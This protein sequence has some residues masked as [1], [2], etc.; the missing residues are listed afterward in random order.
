[1]DE[2]TLNNLRAEIQFTPRQ[3]LRDLAHLLPSTTERERWS[4][5]KARLEA[6]TGGVAPSLFMRQYKRAMGDIELAEAFQA[7]RPEGCFC[8]GAGEKDGVVC[9]CPEAVAAQ[10]E[11]AE[12]AAKRREADIKS[13]FDNAGVP[14]R[15]RSFTLET[16]PGPQEFVQVVSAMIARGQYSAYLYGEYGS[17]KTGLAVSMLRERIRREY[18]SGYFVTVPDLL[19]RIRQTY[20]REDGADETEGEL[21]RRV[22]S[23]PYLILDDIG[24]ERASDW[25]RERLFTILNWR[26]GQQLDTLFTS[27]LTLDQLAGQIGERIVWRIAEMSPAFPITGINLR[28]AK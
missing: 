12:R 20:S 19:A 3:R 13:W 7:T 11:G 24:A 18:A 22:R 16:Y 10:H 1:M 23:T 4:K 28:A 9:T 26:H 2:A 21:M 6:Q 5:Q 14:P 15:F 17:G 25:V 8:L 27:N